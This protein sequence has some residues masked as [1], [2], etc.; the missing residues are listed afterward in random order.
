MHFNAATIKAELPDGLVAN[1]NYASFPFVKDHGET[2]FAIGSFSY[3]SL[4]DVESRLARV[5]YS[6]VVWMPDDEIFAN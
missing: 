5:S 6:K 3:C 4:K 2:D 1:L